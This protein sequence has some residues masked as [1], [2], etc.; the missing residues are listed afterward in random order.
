[1]VISREIDYAARIVRHLSKTEMANAAQIESAESISRDFVRKILRKLKKAGYISTE[2][3]TKGGY[4]LTVSPEDI[5]LWDLK[6]AIEPGPV[7]NKCLNKG[8]V[9]PNNCEAPCSIHIECQRLEGILEEEM[10]KRN[11]FEILAES[12]K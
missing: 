8:F 11:I 10:K 3:G 7:I 4:S 5:T 12:E 1:M 2:R 6:Y 9:C